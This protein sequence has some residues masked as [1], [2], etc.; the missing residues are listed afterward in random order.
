MLSPARLAPAPRTGRHLSNPAPGVEEA[1]ELMA[2]GLPAHR[3]GAREGTAGGASRP[4]SPVH[5]AAWATE[6]VPGE[7]IPIPRERGVHLHG[8]PG[9]ARRRRGCS[10]TALLVHHAN[11]GS[12]GPPVL[13]TDAPDD[14]ERYPGTGTT[15]PSSGMVIE[16]LRPR[17]ASRATERI[18]LK[19]VLLPGR[20]P[21][22]CSYRGARG[23]SRDRAVREGGSDISMSGP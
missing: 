18:P 16:S 1:F 12:Q 23:T 11:R 4:R 9:G 14:R 6:Q 13:S 19:L 7:Q 21:S 10:L 22:I 8:G 17:S 3:P 20:G 15:T 5:W 2:P